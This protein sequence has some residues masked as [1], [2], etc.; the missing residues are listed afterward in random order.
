MVSNNPTDDQGAC[1]EPPTDAF[2]WKVLGRLDFYIGTTNFKATLLIT[3]NTFILG[4]IALKWQDFVT[5]M[6]VSETAQN[7][8]CLVI[9]LASI[10]SLASVFVALLAVLPFLESPRIPQKYHS[11]IFFKDIAEYRDESAY[12]ESASSMTHREMIKDLSNQAYSISAGLNK[13][14]CRLSQATNLLI[15][16]PIFGIGVV[17]L[18]KILASIGWI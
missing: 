6:D 8:L 2:L 11:N 5:G 13:K 9:L 12:H 4:S 1:P 16:G 15:Y 17:L 3:L 14:F 18:I 10:S 7:V